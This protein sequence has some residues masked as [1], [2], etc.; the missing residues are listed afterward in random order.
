[1]RII[2]KSLLFAAVS[3]TTL[4]CPGP[5]EAADP[6]DILGEDLTHRGVD[7]TEGTDPSGEVAREPEGG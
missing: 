2:L 1:M 5:K 4:G 7:G 6:R 3:A